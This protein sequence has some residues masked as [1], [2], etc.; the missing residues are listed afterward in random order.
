MATAEQ[1]RHGIS[2]NLALPA[3]AAA[4]NDLVGHL[5]AD[6]FEDLR[7]DTAEGG[8]LAAG[9]GA[10]ELEPGPAAR[11]AASRTRWRAGRRETS[12]GRSSKSSGRGSGLRLGVG[13]GRLK[14]FWG[15]RRLTRM[16]QT[17]AGK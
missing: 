15:A 8:R 13:F 6:F 17:R 16:G 4:W 2:G 9:D 10:R 1:W 14:R 5:R 12:R 3:F 7:P 11:P